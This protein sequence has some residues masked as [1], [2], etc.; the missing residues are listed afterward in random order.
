MAHL[1][2]A[3]NTDNSGNGGAG[4][5][6]A[7]ATP[8]SGGNG[9]YGGGGGGGSSS[10]GAGNSGIGGG[11]IQGGAAGGGGGTCAI[12]TCT[13]RS[14]GAGG[15]VPG[16]GGGGGTAGV[17]AG[18]SGGDGAN[19]SGSGGDGGGG[20]ANNPTNGGAGGNGGNGGARGGGGGGGGASAGT[21]TQTGG[22]GGTGGTG[23]LRTWTLRGTGADL[24]E[25]Y[26]T[27]DP[28]L[29]AGDVVSIDP[30]LKAGVKKTGQMYD[31][32]AI[33]IISTQPGLTIGDVYA[34]G[35]KPVLVALSGRVPV[36]VSAENGP[37]VAGDPLTPSSIPGIAM[38]ADKA[39]VIVGQAL[40]GSDSEGPGFVVAFINNSYAQGSKLA[41]LLPGTV[42][43]QTLQQR[44][45]AYFTGNS[46]NLSQ[47]T[48]LSEILTDRLSAALEIITPNVITD[49]LATR[50]IT[51]SAGDGDIS[52]LLRS[53]SLVTVQNSDTQTPV[54]AFDSAGNA[55]FSGTLTADKIRANQ[56]E[57][58]EFI[59]SQ[60]NV[61]ADQI[62]GLSA[63]PPASV[64]SP[65]PTGQP[66][67][68][69]ALIDM[70]T[71]AQL[72]ITGALTVEG[73]ANF[74]NI[75]ISGLP[76]FNSDT[77]GFA[78]IKPGADEVRVLFDQE[79]TNTPIVNATITVGDDITAEQLILASDVRFII[80]R[81]NTKGF[82]IKLFSPALQDIPFSWTALAVKDSKLFESLP[83]VLTE[84]LASPTPT[85][86][87]IPLPT[88]TFSSA[89][90]AAESTLTEP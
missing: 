86:E 65:S 31:R 53:H 22:T 63:T 67:P 39:G 16:N 26:S 59:T 41:E 54:I 10:T 5:R 58:M 51:S 4:G 73:D 40:T 44:A 50:T 19:G 43:G 9:G 57:G 76:T 66:I 8:A 23:Y 29:E 17:G 25:F 30:D 75:N 72:T 89:T 48:D 20:G 15:K 18:V 2:A 83:T 33:G 7:A 74:G 3:A 78:V 61:L 13:Q 14:G 36:K 1:G 35:V 80:T 56:I 6:T 70:T 52:L 82:V 87:P 85:P 47:S 28:D 45:L 71:L 11:S 55:T 12:T 79:Y 90:P 32:T 88:M 34:E 46:L 24:A 64:S 60:V 27:N 37:I 21:G 68:T 38:K 62:L 81:R 69:P 77:A 84:I 42:S 49:G